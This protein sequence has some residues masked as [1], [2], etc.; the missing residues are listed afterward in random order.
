MCLPLHIVL[1]PHTKFGKCRSRRAKKHREICQFFAPIVTLTLIVPKRLKSYE[2]NLQAYHLECYTFQKMYLWQLRTIWFWSLFCFIE[3]HYCAIST[4]INL[5]RIPIRRA[6][7]RS[8]RRDI[9]WKIVLGDSWFWKDEYDTNLCIA[10]LPAKKKKINK[11][12][13]KI[14]VKVMALWIFFFWPSIFWALLCFA[15]EL[16]LLF[17]FV[18]NISRRVMLCRRIFLASH[19]WSWFVINEFGICA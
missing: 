3:H 15:D 16:L 18:V 8:S 19:S 13:C 1:D 5:I 7:S 2:R 11:Y 4:L 6:S 9:D 12:A 10:I 14:D 17:F